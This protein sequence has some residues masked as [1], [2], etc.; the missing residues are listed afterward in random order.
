MHKQ[1][2]G[3]AATCFSLRLDYFVCIVSFVS[4]VRTSVL[5]VNLLQ[6]LILLQVPSPTLLVLHKGS[7]KQKMHSLNENYV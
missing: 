1:V 7:T 6:P 4:L 3:S 2:A 5:E